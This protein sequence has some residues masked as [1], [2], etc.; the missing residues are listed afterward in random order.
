MVIIKKKSVLF[1][2]IVVFLIFFSVYLTESKEKNEL[3]IYSGRN[4]KLIEPLI[5]S[6]ENNTKIKINLVTGKSDAF[7]ERL[8]LEGSNTPADILL[9]TDVARLTRAKDSNL[10]KSIKSEILKKNIPNKYKSID[11]DWFGFSI[12]AR[13]I[14]YST[15]RVKKKDLSTYEN[16][17]D[18]K[19]KKRI[20]MR[21]SSNVYNQSFVASM[22]LNA[23]KK[24]TEKWIQGLVKNFAKKPYGNDRDQIRAI[25]AGECDVTIANTYYL[26]KMLKSNKKTDVYAAQNV[27]IFWPNQNSSGTHINISGA[28]IIKDSKNE[29]N[30]IKFLEF[31]S[32]KEAQSIYTKEINEY[33]IRKDV[34]PSETVSKFGKFVSSNLQLN[35]I[36]SELKQAIYITTKN[37]WR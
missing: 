28:G 3:N 24:N 34:P 11:N 23:G 8:K 13:P 7:I 21:S 22:I 33:S 4:S 12:R 18:K 35:K 6:F 32:T 17:V 16:L 29:I 1:I 25:S 10:L 26:A 27:S 30:A 36:S 9:T 19:W 20:C 14:I 31:L 2:F 37:G 15:Q 5:T